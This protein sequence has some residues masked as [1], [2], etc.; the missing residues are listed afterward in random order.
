MFDTRC[1]K[2]IS[3]WADDWVNFGLSVSSSPIKLPAS[4]PPAVRQASPQPTVRQL[5]VKNSAACAKGP[6]DFI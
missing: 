5:N 3:T 1:I 2:V 6:E 4:S